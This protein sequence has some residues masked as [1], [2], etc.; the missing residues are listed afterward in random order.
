M[1]G[2][3]R[4]TEAGPIFRMQKRKLGKQQKQ[5]LSNVIEQLQKD[6]TTGL[7]NKGDLNEVWGY[8]HEDNLGKVYLG[9]K[10]D[11]DTITL[12]SLSRISVK[13]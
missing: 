9:Y 4:R 10:F 11:D 7:P 12:I 3:V 2:L 5:I 13:I 1:G 6:P 8:L